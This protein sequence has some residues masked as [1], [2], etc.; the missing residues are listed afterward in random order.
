[1]EFYYT[2]LNYEHLSLFLV[3]IGFANHM[4]SMGIVQVMD[5]NLVS[6]NRLVTLHIKH[7][8]IEHYVTYT[9]IIFDCTYKECLYGITSH[10]SIISNEYE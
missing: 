6:L 4:L 7:N 8:Y 3:C 2:M 9:D 10:N 5:S 1:M